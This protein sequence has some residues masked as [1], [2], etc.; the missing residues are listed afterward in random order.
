MRAAAA[1]AAAAAA[2][3]VPLVSERPPAG[4]GAAG[5]SGPQPCADEAPP[6]LVPPPTP[7][8]A[9][10]QS[11]LLNAKI[12]HLRAGLYSALA[13]ISFILIVLTFEGDQSL[14]HRTELTTAMFAIMGPAGLLGAAGSWAWLR[15][16]TK[17]S[18][19]KFRRGRWAAGGRPGRSQRRGAKGP[20]AP[21]APPP[22]RPLPGRFWSIL[23]PS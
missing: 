4:I 18:L 20:T 22:P 1:A 15:F 11:P 12:N 3:A 10:R 7:S 9:R 14:A 8:R 5:S 13:W 19:E 16:R 6:T 21:S 2:V 17:K 23:L